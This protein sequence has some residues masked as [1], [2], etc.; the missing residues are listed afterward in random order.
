[1]A[2]H[3]LGVLDLTTAGLGDVMGTERADVVYSAPPWGPGNLAYWRT[4]NKDSHRPSWPLFLERFCAE[5]A[6]YSTG[7]VFVEMGLRWETELV[8]AMERA[9]LPF[10]QR[11]ECLYGNPKRP[12]ALCLFRSAP[13]DPHGATGKGGPDL[14]RW[15]LGAVGVGP[16]QIVLDPCTGLGTTARV[17]VERGAVFRGAELNPERAARAMQWLKP[18]EVMP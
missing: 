12:N 10:V 3:R 6:R 17:A 4:V 16:G 9:G 7:P 14:V 1:M 8:A 18:S 15:A 11:W 5:V 13:L 2:E